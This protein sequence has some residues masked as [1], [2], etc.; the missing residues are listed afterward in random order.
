MRSAQTQVQAY[1]SQDG[2][3]VIQKYLHG[4]PHRYPTRDRQTFACDPIADA[5]AKAADIIS[6]DQTERNENKTNG[7]THATLLQYL[8]ELAAGQFRF[9][10][11]MV[12]NRTCQHLGRVTFRRPLLQ[13]DGEMEPAID[14][15]RRCPGFDV[16]IGSG[17]KILVQ[18]RRRVHGVEQLREF[19]HSKRQTVNWC[20]TR[21]LGHMHACILVVGGATLVGFTHQ[22]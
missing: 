10:D 12:M 20:V 11:E 4:F 8:V 16:L 14:R 7:K 22:L 5:G 19:F 3:P 17:I 2:P 21:G 1:L 18:K 15:M 9:I 13:M 6:R